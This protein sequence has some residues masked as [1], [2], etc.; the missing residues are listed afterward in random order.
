MTVRVRDLACSKTGIYDP[1]Q[2]RVHDQGRKNR[3]TPTASKSSV[4]IVV[5]ARGF[6]FPSSRQVTDTHHSNL[7]HESSR[8]S[9][10]G[11]PPFHQQHAGRAARQRRG[12]PSDG[13]QP[14]RL[15]RNRGRVQARPRSG[16]RPPGRA[17]Q[18]DGK[19][20]ARAALLQ[21]IFLRDRQGAFSVYG[22]QG[23]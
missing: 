15:E 16:R 12:R 19:P 2:P 9:W 5:R 11:R 4:E 6:C 14:T 10:V 1:I 8:D 17:E 3:T 18:L 23:W 7:H 13:H 22:R 21:R 20:G